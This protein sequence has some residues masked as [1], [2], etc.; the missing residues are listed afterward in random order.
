MKIS[1]SLPDEEVAY[2]DAFAR[3]H[4]QTRSAALLRAVRLL[5]QMDLAQDYAAAWEEWAESGD[6]EVWEAAVRDGVTQLAEG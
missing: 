2:L 1:V 3:S 5:R 4:D 6:A